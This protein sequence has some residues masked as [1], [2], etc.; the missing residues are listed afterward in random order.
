MKLIYS[1]QKFLVMAL[2]I[3]LSPASWARHG[4]Q[5]HEQALTFQEEVEQMQYVYQDFLDE[6]PYRHNRKLKRIDNKL[7]RL[8]AV[9][10]KLARSLAK[11]RRHKAREHLADARRIARRTGTILNT[12]RIT[13]DV[14]HQWRRVKRALNRIQLP[15]AAGF[16]GHHYI[17]EV[18]DDEVIGLHNPR[19]HE[20]VNEDDVIEV[21]PRPSAD[22]TALVDQIEDLS[23]RVKNTFRK[24][25]KRKQS[26]EKTLDGQLS[27]FDQLA[28]QLRDRW[29]SSHS[30]SGIRSTVSS[31]KQQSRGIHGIITRYP[32]NA[33]VKANWLNL[34]SQLD[35]LAGS[36]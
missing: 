19:H 11:G 17:E 30:T 13:P 26:W 36:L 5:V 34:K 23:E 32:V 1:H 28:N 2:L 7:E 24:T 35:Q 18:E 10:A 33:R 21:N 22:L 3:L 29:K 6:R 15:V 20:Y 31:L 16:A 14:R 27:A 9:A 25:S 4:G 8:D 12:V